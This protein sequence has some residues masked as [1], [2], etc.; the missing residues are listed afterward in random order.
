MTD[1]VEQKTETSPVVTEKPKSETTSAGG[2][3]ILGAA[4]G[5]DMLDEARRKEVE[6]HFDDKT[7]VEKK[8]ILDQANKAHGA[9]L[10][11]MKQLSST[12]VEAAKIIEEINRNLFQQE[13]LWDFDHDYEDEKGVL[14]P[15]YK[16]FFEQEV[17]RVD[18]DFEGDD[19]PT[20][21]VQLLAWEKLRN[22]LESQIPK[23]GAGEKVVKLKYFREYAKNAITD[24]VV[25][26]H[27]KENRTTDTMN[28][29]LLSHIDVKPVETWKGEAGRPNEEELNETM[30]DDF[31]TQKTQTLSILGQIDGVL[32]NALS[33]KS[34]PEEQKTAYLK[35][36]SDTKKLMETNPEEA[37]KNA[38]K[39]HNDV[40]KSL[41]R[42][43]EAVIAAATSP[44][45]APSAAPTAAPSSAETAGK[46]KDIVKTPEASSNGP[47]QKPS[48]P[49]SKAETPT[50]TPAVSSEKPAD[51]VDAF[52]NKK[53]EKSP[54][55]SGFLGL[56]GIKLEDVS[57]FFK[58][59]FEKVK[60]FFSENKTIQGLKEKFSKALKGK[61]SKKIASSSS[62]KE[63]SL[64]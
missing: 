58:G 50:G 37:L 9:L 57:L 14:Q 36:L 10:E 34:I 62:T 52:I 53:V 54:W 39:L 18:V 56:M 20:N 23:G 32:H 48:T 33:S 13:I 64:S 31:A 26:L 4:L 1:G 46:P 49:P 25:R 17:T 12:K 61:N 30:T 43:G 51:P 3:D 15:G 8:V 11:R 40:E 59:L 38:Q 29:E 5:T 35:Q 41:A 24:F 22:S 21:E 2:K 42:K 55:I 45:T 63:R 7:F 27:E 6:A 44:L 28:K 47:E 16:K 19:G 60:V